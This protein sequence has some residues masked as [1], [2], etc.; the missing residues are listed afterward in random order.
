[1]RLELQNTDVFQYSLPHGTSKEYAQNALKILQIIE[2]IQP[3]LLSSLLQSDAVLTLSGVRAFDTYLSFEKLTDTEIDAAISLLEANG[4]TLFANSSE[5]DAT[6]KN[7]YS[8][9]HHDALSKIPQQ[10]KLSAWV[11]PHKPFTFDRLLSWSYFVESGI[12]RAIETGEL[13][14][15][16]GVNRRTA[17]N[18]RFGIL[19]GYP[20]GAITSSCW[21][22]V[23]QNSDSR[24]ELCQAKIA[25]F[26]MYDAA[27]PIYFYSKKLKNDTLITRHQAL[28]SEI[29]TEVYESPW[30]QKLSL[31]E[32]A[33][34]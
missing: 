30:Y 27:Q 20:G 21:E 11:E 26:D 25:Y 18:I 24:P 23:Q 15:E 17:H 14:K 8:L 32:K 22:D 3:K 9:M 6:G 28:W 34:H 4:L 10:Y 33:I 7:I 16:W 13:P 19:L 2:K 29:L 1:M 5:Y 12:F 31:Q